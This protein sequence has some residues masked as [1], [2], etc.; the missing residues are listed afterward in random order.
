MQQKFLEVPI[1]KDFQTVE[2]CTLEYDP[3][4]GASIDPHIDDCWVWGERIVTVN[5]M[6]NSILT[7]IPYYGP[8]TKYNLKSIA[9]Y[10]TTCE[11][12]K[13]DV[14]NEN[15]KIQDKV[16]RLPM[17]EGSLMVLYGAAR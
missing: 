6:G 15:E 5:V 17:P 1:L 14:R 4:R 9:E 10:S 3:L 8:D 2:Q 13:F 16:I 7:M 11:N 12:M